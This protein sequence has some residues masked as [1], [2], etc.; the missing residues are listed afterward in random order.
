MTQ[1]DYSP[2]LLSLIFA[3]AALAASAAA[4]LDGCTVGPDFTPPPAPATA[5]YTTEKTPDLMP[6]DSAEAAQ[7]IELGKKIAADWWTLFHSPE[8]NELIQDAIANNHT[9]EAAK[10]TLAEAQEQVTASGGPLYPKI[11]LGASAARQKFG[12]GFAGGLARSIP[13]FSAFSIGPTVSYALDLFG[14]T[15]RAIE[16]QKALAD[17]QGYELDA[18]YLTLTG[19][20][21]TEALQIASI[22]AQ[23]DAVQS[24]LDDDERTLDL[25][26][27]QRRAGTVS[28]V[29]VLSSESQLAN[30]RT[31]LPPLR[32]QETVA[33]HAL[34]ILVGKAPGDWSP[35]DFDLA[36]L[37]LPAELPLGVP[38]DL[39]HDRP[40]IQASEAQLHAASA[41]IGVATANM[42]P[43]IT[44]SASFALQGLSPQDIFPANNEAWSLIGS[45]A[46]PIFHGGQLSAEKRAAVDEFQASLAR[47]QQTVL[48]SFGQ[49]ADVLGALTQ[50]RDQLTAQKDA[51]HTAQSSL[52]LTRLSYSAGTSNIVQVL[53]AQRLDQQA[54]L[55]YVRAQ[56]Q[57]YLDSTQLFLAAGGGTLQTNDGPT[58]IAQG[59]AGPKN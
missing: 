3:R 45:A 49:V 54:E 29:D 26:R 20:V 7:H 14:G 19:N 15:R 44:L 52:K 55:G 21:V 17:Y 59:T 33:R 18:A 4:L 39:V 12:P 28:D 40:D 34:A 32:Q 46:A 42:Y 43:Q 41:A 16:Q 2:S 6:A 38:S 37:T 50:D 5:N 53:D 51:L 56:A 11:D 47:Y 57:R 8:L 9:L 58:P 25:V 23:I 27:Q 36:Q 10:A 24:I 48:S 35:P 13:P 22:R 1:S 30:D 31:L